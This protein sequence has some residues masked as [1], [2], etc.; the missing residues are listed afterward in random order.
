MESAALAELKSIL[1]GCIAADEIEE[2]WQEYE[3]G[4]T[5]NAKLVKDFD[6]VKEKTHTCILYF[7]GY[8]SLLISIITLK[9]ASM[10]LLSS[11]FYACYAD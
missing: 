3:K 2:L 11:N 9:N 8:P 7:R 6:K 4:E 10:F 1:G 5:E